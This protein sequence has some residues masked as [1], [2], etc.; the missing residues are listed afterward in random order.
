MTDKVEE[1]QMNEQ[2]YLDL[3]NQLKEKFDN[4]EYLMK[5]IQKQNMELKKEIV[6]AFGCMRILDSLIHNSYGVDGDI[7]SLSE[8]LRGHLSTFV[9]DII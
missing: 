6:T 1:I 3:V 2:M 7:I 4:N 8:S 9:E 5:R